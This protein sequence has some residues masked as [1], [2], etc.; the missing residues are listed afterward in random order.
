MLVLLAPAEAPAAAAPPQAAPASAAALQELGKR[1]AMH[2]AAARPP[3][4]RVEDVPAAEVERE[5]GV[6]RA[7]AQAS[8]KE[9]K[10]L[11]S[12]L[13]GRLQ[14]FF[15]DSCLLEQAFVLDEKQR[16]GALVKAAGAR[17]LDFRVFV[18]GEAGGGPGAAAAGGGGAA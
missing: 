7:L 9:G 11:D 6:L 1:V 18:V 17:V 12:M 16:V 13:K 3:F 5:R 14:K 8:G 2:I 15:A 10:H 4:L